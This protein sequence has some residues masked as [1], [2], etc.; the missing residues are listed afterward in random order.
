MLRLRRNCI[1]LKIE[2]LKKAFHKNEV[3][4]GVDL[5]VNPGEVVGI[6]G[7]SG[8]GTS[9]FLRCV[10]LLEKPDAGHFTFNT[11]NFDMAAVNKK[12]ILA[13]RRN[14]AMV[15]QQFNLFKYKTALENVM[16]GLIVVQKKDK[17]LAKEEARQYLE[18]VGLKDRMNYY[19]SQLS[20]G[21]QQ[22]VAIARSMALKPAIIL[23][24]EPTS[25]LDPEMIGEVLQVI[26]SIAKSGNT[27][28]IVSHEMSFI[29]EIANHVIFLEGGR[30]LEEGSPQDIFSHPREERTKQFIS[31]VSSFGDFVI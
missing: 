31:K 9:T 23:F 14:T 6:I 11:L 27:L 22:R 16:E 1:M 5:L 26:K 3:L 17:T 13:V 10:N 30:I 15:F 19:P 28:I 24:D 25:A 2:G 12:D 18:K 21:Q 8:S 29:S 7:P 20:G 4:K